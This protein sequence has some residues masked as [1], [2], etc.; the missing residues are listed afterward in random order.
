MLTER[1]LEIVLSV[2][3]E[4]IQTGEPAGSRTISKKYLR[5]SSPATIRNE[6]ADLEEMGYFYQPHTSAG[7]LPTSKAYRLYV[8]SIMQRRRSAPAE[9]ER[10]KKE[11][12]DRREGVDSILGYVS[13]LLGKATNCVGVAALSALEEVQIQRVNFVRLGGS[14]VLMLIVLEGGLVHHANINLPCELSQDILDDLARKISTVACGHPW[15]QVR[16]ALFTYVLDGLERVW[17]T[18]REALVQM[19]AILKRNSRLFVGGAQHILNLPDFQDIGK[20]Q[21][22]L[23][24]LEQEQAL[25]DMVERYSV[26]Q[27]VSVTIGEEISQEMKEC[28]LVLV[29]ASG[30]GRRTILGLIG[31]LRMDYEKSISILEAIAEELDKAL[32][33]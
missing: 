28:S 26:K 12:R 33:N 22:V 17:D 6:M 31:P 25:A 21:T 4:Y 3:Y 8:D 30:Y 15:A 16:D 29:P 27:G 7:R 24:L 18:C 23:S 9:T 11:I 32:V 10:W 14:T 2:V 13:Q 5:G 20:F 1:Q 19:D